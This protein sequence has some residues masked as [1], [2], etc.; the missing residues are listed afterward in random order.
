VKRVKFIPIKKWGKGLE[1][2]V[3][4][5]KLGAL[6]KKVSKCWPVSINFVPG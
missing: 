3:L 2:F 5:I 4:K 1:Y 6:Y